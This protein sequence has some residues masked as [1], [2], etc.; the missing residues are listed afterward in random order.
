MT[1]EYKPEDGD[2]GCYEVEEVVSIGENGVVYTR[3]STEE[4][5]TLPQIA[6]RDGKIPEVNEN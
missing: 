2:G 4:G 5:E 6:P 3:I 1:N